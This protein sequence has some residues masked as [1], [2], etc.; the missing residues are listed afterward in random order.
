MRSVIN[1]ILLSLLAV[2]LVACNADVLMPSPTASPT[3]VPIKNEPSNQN[4]P[5][6]VFQ[7]SGGFAGVT[8]Q[9]ALYADGRIE[10]NTGS[11]SQ[12]TP[13]QVDQLLSEIE[14]LGFF[15][16]NSRYVPLNTCCDRILYELSVGRDGREHNLTV[17]DA[18]PD[19]PE[20]VWDVLN[21]VSDF[22]AAFEK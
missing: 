13:E 8:N 2:T 12:A 4:A 6:L 3:P 20:T 17:L 18:T 19:L 14:Q 10:A 11:Y 22:F 1:M 5:V 15:K 7:Q 16:L 21:T 9:W